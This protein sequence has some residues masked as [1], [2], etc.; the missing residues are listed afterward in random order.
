[1]PTTRKQKTKTRKSREPDLL[2]DIENLDTMLGT[3]NFQREE[4]ELSNSV[5]RPESPRYNAW[6]NNDTNSHYNSRENELRG[7]AGHGDNSGGSESIIEFNR[8]SGELNQRGNG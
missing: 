7:F 4:S 6:V 2:S 5:R 3:N 1:M 8:L